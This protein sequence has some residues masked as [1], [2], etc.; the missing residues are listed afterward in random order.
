MSHDTD[1]IE[2]V[3]ASKRRRAKGL[4]AWAEMLARQGS[5]REAQAA[6][7]A[8]SSGGYT[9]V[10]RD[11]VSRSA[12]ELSGTRRFKSAPSPAAAAPVNRV[13]FHP[14]QP[15]VVATPARPATPRPDNAAQAI[16]NGEVPT[17]APEAAPDR[18]AEQAA[19]PLQ[20]R[21]AADIE[22]ILELSSQAGLQTDL[23]ERVGVTDS[24]GT[25]Q[26]ERRE[27][28]AQPGVDAPDSFRDPALE[29]A[30]DAARAAALRSGVGANPQLAA[31]DY[32]LAS[33]LP[34]VSDTLGG[35]IYEEF[36]VAL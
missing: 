12:K 33:Q 22:K 21:G 32:V 30:Q 2:E 13:S 16:A 1:A 14:P 10:P 20:A 36:R 7:V 4:E 25:D 24:D 23:S 35:A 9:S 19:A 15:P 17:A 3:Q 18:A 6:P 5:R 28:A 34:G 29:Q 26:L 8:E 31:K 11:T 27:V